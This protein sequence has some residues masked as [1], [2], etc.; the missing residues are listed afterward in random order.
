METFNQPSSEFTIYAIIPDEPR[1]RLTVVYDQK[2]D[3]DVE[4]TDELVRHLNLV[5]PL[6]MTRPILHQTAA[7]LKIQD[8]VFVDMVGGTSFGTRIVDAESMQAWASKEISDEQF[9]ERWVTPMLS[10]DELAEE[11]DRQVIYVVSGVDVTQATL[12]YQDP[13]GGGEQHETAL[14]WVHSFYAAPGQSLSLSAQNVSDVGLVACDIHLGGQ[15]LT[16]S[17]SEGGFMTAT[18]SGAVP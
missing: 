1:G 17:M 13:E 3:T 4:V 16:R 8:V 18:C 10:E 9:A 6:E 14:P 12:T 2:L 7:S 5:G 11:G 15:L